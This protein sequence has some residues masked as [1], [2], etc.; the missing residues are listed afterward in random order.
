MFYL[1]VRIKH[2]TLECNERRMRALYVQK[3]DDY[4]RVVSPHLQYVP[5]VQAMTVLMPR[6]SL[7]V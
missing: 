5:V 2:R 4:S 1:R 6:V 3:L 7:P